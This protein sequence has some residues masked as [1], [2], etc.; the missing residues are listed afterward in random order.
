MAEVREMNEQ[1][2]AWVCQ[3]CGLEGIPIRV[4]KC[5]ACWAPL[6]F[7]EFDCGGAFDGFRVSSDADGGL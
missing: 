5:P 7:D 2:T 1:I 6:A 3:E 4:S